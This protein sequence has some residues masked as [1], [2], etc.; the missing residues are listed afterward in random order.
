MFKLTYS[1]KATKSL[2]P[3]IGIA[4]L[5][6]GDHFG[7]SGSLSYLLTIKEKN[8]VQFELSK[9][10]YRSN[11]YAIEKLGQF[12]SNNIISASVLV[13]RTLKKGKKLSISPMVGAFVRNHKWIITTKTGSYTLGEKHYVPPFSSALFN[14]F[15]IGYSV[16]VAFSFNI[17]NNKSISLKPYYEN[18]NNGYSIIGLKTG[19]N[20]PIK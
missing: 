2:R 6:A 9:Q 7:Y 5:G 13:G 14:D 3:E 15:G 20:F 1:Q 16:S 19:I 10:A 11:R 18:D 4:M 17:K 8:I 12:I